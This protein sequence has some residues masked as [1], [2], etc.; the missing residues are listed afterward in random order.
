MWNEQTKEL[1]KI[2]SEVI[3]V[4]VR[5]GKELDNLGHQKGRIYMGGYSSPV[6]PV[7]PH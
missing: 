5:K 6:C 2:G 7:F 1:A 4:A 3:K